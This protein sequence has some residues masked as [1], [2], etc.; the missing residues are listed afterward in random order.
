MEIL[1]M[2]SMNKKKG[3]GFGFDLKIWV[4]FEKHPYIIYKLKNPNK[5]LNICI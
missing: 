3:V 2:N 4:V 5:N 1:L